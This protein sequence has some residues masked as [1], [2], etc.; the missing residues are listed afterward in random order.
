MVKF[1]KCRIKTVRLDPKYVNF[2]FFRSKM[3]NYA[4]TSVFL[5]GD[6]AFWVPQIHLIQ[7]QAKNIKN[8]NFASEA[9]GISCIPP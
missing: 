1:K 2:P 7:K 4:L 8:Q 3:L 5:N 9:V 6:G